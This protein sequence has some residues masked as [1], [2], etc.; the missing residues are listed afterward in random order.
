M[1]L[2]LLGVGEVP[3]FVRTVR[4]TPV[5]GRRTVIAAALLA[6]HFGAWIAS[7]GMTTVLRSTAIVAL[8]PVFAGL[9]GRVLGDRVSSWMYIGAAVSLGGTWVLVGGAG[10]AA[11]G[12]L[13]GDALALVGAGA[14][15]GYLA[16]GRSL[17]AD[18]PLRAYLGSVHVVAGLLL[19]LVAAG[20][21]LPLQVAPSSVAI[22][23]VLYLGLVPGVIGHGLFN[24]VVRRAPVDRVAVAI[25]LEPVGATLLA[26]AVLGHGVTGIE[27]VG[28]SVVLL[29]VAL[30]SIPGRAR[31]AG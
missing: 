4:R 31:R 1:A 12:S 25:L 15:A 5:V 20:F 6:L 27:V 8:Q 19:L 10:A 14:A 3:G 28:A 30:G 29:G 18:V 7:L 21:V 23:S 13:A 2:L 17:R 26:W 16:V 24:W 9:L 22:V 11:G